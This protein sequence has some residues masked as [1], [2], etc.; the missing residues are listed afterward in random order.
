MNSFDNGLVE[1]LKR[2][3]L[4]TEP[5]GIGPDEDFRRPTKAAKI[6]KAALS[7]MPPRRMTVEE[8][9]YEVYKAVGPK[10]EMR[11]R[12]E[13]ARALMTLINAGTQQQWKPEA[14]QKLHEIGAFLLGE[15]QY[16]GLSFGDSVKHGR[17][18]ARFWWRR[19]LR[20]ILDALPTPPES[21]G[22]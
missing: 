1:A 2:I 4:M 5:S 7:A 3:A 15:A 18:Q 16:M 17:T 10:L 19:D 20:K 11:D 13:I 14:V 12:K 8:V 21:K 22:V 6:A 9:A